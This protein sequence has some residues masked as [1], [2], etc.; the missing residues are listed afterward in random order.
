M[1]SKCI[2]YYLPSQTSRNQ[3]LV[4]VQEPLQW[5]PSSCLTPMITLEIEAPFSKMK[6]APSDPLKDGISI[7]ATGAILF[8]NL[9][10][11][12]SVAS[13]SNIVF[14]VTVVFAAGNGGRTWKSNNATNSRWDVQSLSWCDCC[15]DRSGQSS[16]ELHSE[17]GDLAGK[18]SKCLFG[19]VEERVK[20]SSER[21]EEWMRVIRKRVK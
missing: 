14:L 12:V 5:T 6:T 1:I 16:C 7:R 2:R 10:I 4:N 17:E 3:T 15:E 20:G 13:T 18:N 11:G 21:R 9:P 8:S 19:W